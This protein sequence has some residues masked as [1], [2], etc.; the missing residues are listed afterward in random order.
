M[1]GA[2]Y[3]AEPTGDLSAAARDNLQVATTQQAASYAAGAAQAGAMVHDE[4][5]KQEQAYWRRL[6]G[7]RRTPMPRKKV[8]PIDRLPLP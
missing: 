1:D 4:K 7:L 2:M 8:S 3:A 5:T 6:A